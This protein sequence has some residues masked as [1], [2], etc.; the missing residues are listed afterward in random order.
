MT[1]AGLVSLLFFAAVTAIMGLVRKDEEL[2]RT[3]ARLDA[4]LRAHETTSAE[5]DRLGAAFEGA[6]RERERLENEVAELKALRDGDGA[7]R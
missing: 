5:R 4:A 3:R 1:M 6:A 7:Y 2:R